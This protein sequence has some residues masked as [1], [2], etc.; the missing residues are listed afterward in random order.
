MLTVGG[1]IAIWATDTQ[2]ESVF[3]RDCGVGTPKYGTKCR[4]QTNKDSTA[5]LPLGCA[6]Q[7]IRI[8]KLPTL[9]NF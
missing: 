6:F 7:Y 3:L 1:G 8:I 9:K 2:V 4:R 5:T